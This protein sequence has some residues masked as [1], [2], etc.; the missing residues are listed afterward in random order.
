MFQNLANFTLQICACQGTVFYSN[1][2]QLFL[3]K[4][5]FRKCK[6]KKKLRKKTNQ[7]DR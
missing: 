7:N 5:V 3:N 1:V 6:K 4:A 2:C